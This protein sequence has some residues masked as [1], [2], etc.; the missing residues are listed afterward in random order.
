[1]KAVLLLPA[2]AF[3][4]FAQ[5]VALTF[6]DLPVA[7]GVDA[8]AIGNSIAING[9]ILAS[10]AK[11]HAMAIGFVNQKRVGDPGVLARWI[12]AG[13]QLGNHGYSH[14]DLNE[15]SLAQ[16]EEEV[17]KGEG[18]RKDRYFRF[19]FNHTGETR[20]KH[21]AAAAFLRTRGYTVATCT[22]DNSDYVFAAAYLKGA[23]AQI[24]DAYVE[25]TGKEID[26]YTTLNRQVFGRS[27]PHVMLLHVNRLNADTLD[28]ILDLLEARGY[29]YVTI[30]EAQSDAAYRTPDT[31]VTKFGPMW[32][33]RWAQ[34]LGVK[35]NGRLEPEPPSWLPKL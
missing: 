21:D 30:E 27:I 22:I 29:R 33:Y 20:E 5:S 32:G 16:F 6:D 25:Y 4:C 13:H 7:G 31:Y 34:V 3:G 9:A 26:Y 15:L 18:G 19:P 35:V 17:V 10:L 2:F 23:T 1:M 28:R 12:A 14:A 11:H 24:A 8:T